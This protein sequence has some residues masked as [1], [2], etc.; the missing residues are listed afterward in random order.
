MMLLLILLRLLSVARLGICQG[1]G[2]PIYSTGLDD[3]F[4]PLAPESRD[5]HYVVISAPSGTEATPFAPYVVSTNGYPFDGDWLANDAASQ[6]VGPEPG[7]S[8]NCQAPAGVYD[9]RTS[10]DLTGVDP[11]SV[12]LTFSLL[13]DGFV[14]DVLV[15]GQSAG[16]V[17]PTPSSFVTWS[18][19]FEISN[20]LALGTNTLDFIVASLQ[21]TGCNPSGLR[22][23]IS[24]ALSGGGAPPEI[25]LP[26]LNVTTNQGADVVFSVSATGSQP[27]GYQW[28][29]DQTNVLADATSPT[30]TLSDVQT[31]QAGSYAVIVTNT[32]GSTTSSSAV[33][34]VE[35]PPY[36][37]LQPFDA[38]TNVGATVVLST[39][40]VGTPPPAYQWVY[41]Q[42]NVLTGA[43]G[44][45]L[46]L[47]DIQ[48]NQ[49][50]NYMVIVTNVAGSAT[51]SS[52]V[53]T[54]EVPP[55]ITLQ[56][57]TVTTNQGAIVGFSVTATGTPP[58]AY[59][60]FFNETTL[61]DGANGPTLVLGDVQPDDAGAYAVVV[62]NLAGSAASASAVLTVEVPPAI[63][64]QPV[65]L[66]TTQGATITFSVT[67][68]STTP[69]SYQWSFNGTGIPNATN[70]T[71]TL[72]NVQP[73]NAGSYSVLVTNVGGA[74]PSSDAALIV[75]VPPAGGPGSDAMVTLSA[76]GSEWKIF[77]YNDGS[78]RVDD[79]TNQITVS[80]QVHPYSPQPHGYL[81]SSTLADFSGTINVQFTGR[82]NEYG[83]SSTDNLQNQ[84]NY[85]EPNSA[86]DTGFFGPQFVGSYPGNV[87]SLSLTLPTAMTQNPQPYRL[88]YNGTNETL[89]VWISLP[90]PFNG[91]PPYPS[92]DEAWEIPCKATVT[93][94]GSTITGLVEDASTGQPLAG[95]TAVV[96]AQTFTSDANGSFV[97]PLLPPGPL[98][99]QITAPGYASWQKTEV[100][101][102]FEAVDITFNLTPNSGGPVLSSFASPNGAHFI[103]GMPGT[104]TF[105]VQ[106]AWN[107]SPGTATFDVAGFTYPALITD[108]GGGQASATLT[109]PAP[110]FVN[111]TSQLTV[112]AINGDGHSAS[113]QPQ[114]HFYPVPPIVVD[115]YGDDIPWQMKG[116]A[117]TYSTKLSRT[118]WHQE[119]PSGVYSSTATIGGELS[120]AYDANAGHFTGS[121][122]L[123]GSFDEEIAF[124]GMKNLSEGSLGLG[125]KL[126]VLMAGVDPPTVTPSWEFTV[127][128][129]AGVGGPAAD[130]VGVIFPV[131]EPVIQELLKV[132][133]LGP[134]LKAVQVDAYIVGELEVSGKYA[135][136]Q[137]A[138]CFL[139]TSSID[140]SGSLGFELE[141]PIKLKTLGIP[142]DLSIYGGGTGGPEIQVC[143]ELAFEEIKFQ[144]YGG[145]KYVSASGVTEWD[146]KISSPYL[147][148]TS[149]GSVGLEQAVGPTGKGTE[150][151]WR[152]G[153]EEMLRWGP[154]NRLVKP[155][156]RPG[157]AHPDDGSSGSNGA[158]VV[159]NVTPLS[160]PAVLSDSLGTTV[161]F[162]MTDP[163]QPWN[164]GT[165]IGTAAL[166]GS[167]DWALGSASQE[168][169]ADYCPR[170]IPVGTN[171]ALASW[172]RFV[173]AASG[174][175]NPVDVL[176]DMEIAAAWLDRTTGRWTPPVQL[177]TNSLVDRDPHPV[178][179]A[180]TAGIVWV[181]NLAGD[182][183]GDSVNGDQLLFAGW[184]GTGWDAPQTLWSAT[185]GILGVTFTADGD[186][187]A[188]VVF[189][190]DVD[191]NLDTTA[192]LEL[193]EVS[194]VG[195]IWQPALRL[196]SDQVEDSLPTLVAPNGVP[197][198]VWSAGG[199]LTYSTLVPWNPKPLFSQ[200]TL[201]AQAPTLE[202]ATVPGGA[203]IACTVQTG[204]GVEIASSYY[205]A[206][207]DQWSLPAQ[208]T[209]DGD[210][211]SA[212]S[213]G[214]DGQQVVV[215][216]LKT[217][218][219]WTNVDFQVSGQTVTV[220]NVPQ[221]GRTDLCLLTHSLGV[222]VAVQPGS[223]KFDPPNPAPGSVVTNSAL[224]ENLGDLPVQNLPLGFYDG[225]PTNGGVLI[226]GLQVVPGV[227]AG[228]ETQTVSVVW[229]L[230]AAPQAHQVY[231]VADPGLTLPDTDRSN[232]AASAT[233]VL[234]DIAIV[235][236]RSAFAS[237]SVVQLTATLTNSGVIPTGPFAVSWR[238][239]AVDGEEIG[240]VT[241]DSL[242]PGDEQDVSCH[243]T[244]SG[245]YF[246]SSFV[247]VFVVADPTN[248]VA[249]LDKTNNAAEQS[250]CV[251]P[252]W[253][254]RIVGSRLLQ[255][256]LLELD[257][258]TPI[259]SNSTFAVQST[260]SLDGPVVWTVESSATITTVAPGSYQAQVPVAQG[261]R[262][263]RIGAPP[264]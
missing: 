28:V 44:P 17:I 228:A 186:G 226:G 176:P 79:L 150:E 126:D 188:H 246:P 261:P 237:N 74:T 212:L 84:A 52:A 136:G 227:L 15:N 13:A 222:D 256:G 51:S 96:G 117:S 113:I 69:L 57:V 36:I 232:N 247:A 143:P 26:P 63:T 89:T 122:A 42:T 249:E 67:A 254:P 165:W 179:F 141:V 139:G 9:Y 172:V 184:N 211:A 48:T 199:T 181:Q 47:S 123:Q 20:Q 72:A 166:Q 25:T 60:W 105:S 248:A 41:E 207:L 262:F 204:S 75:N 118:V 152:P 252:G 14:Q 175:T 224:I 231:V 53:L 182:V 134:A 94:N 125:G 5:E 2:V 253:V 209:Q 164:T 121:A 32:A 130:V 195:G 168:P 146:N 66:I 201:S 159:E 124:A 169:A 223:V 244:T 142:G 23:Q 154:A 16:L 73:A 171:M 173:G 101:A 109:V 45:T 22:V 148:L 93:G 161:L 153:G 162:S 55:E 62:T 11:A 190:V 108:L 95:A 7:Y 221:P 97:T 107:G 149:D 200:A 102:P 46:T 243:W 120:A 147:T 197:I 185:S 4:R 80:L 264:Q 37:T 241:V 115:W 31:N 21:Q 215:A 213:L 112:S 137:P 144:V 260:G 178:A 156:T 98:N 56:P 81:F 245:H 183:P 138:R 202:A 258:Q 220:T 239:G 10:F 50:G 259:G 233:A 131:L 128:G 250:V 19:P 12:T 99:I 167:G 119:L 251:V 92:A 157:H 127:S 158:T 160:N 40:A 76:S 103:A 54:V 174:L 49:A 33:L 3:G 38:V 88:Y 242:A 71:L 8:E 193:Y 116:A 135:A 236:C 133:F 218:T 263:F 205:N 219:I 18:G 91:Y 180:N 151:H 170:I 191:G 132:P 192:D 100:L 86:V 155:G 85:T 194:T 68:A 203:V 217:Q 145:I 114:V 24:G 198:C 34:T 229:T 196:T 59:Q 1:T 187:E 111:S 234:P 83:L 257:F 104:L 82:E 189:A 87:A 177:T 35:F 163:S 216:Y 27:L 70:S 77:T 39:S 235:T 225:N 90:S 140:V 30:L 214:W 255:P 238:L 106:I 61:L 240:R 58:L 6:W 129:K 65:S 29:F 208:L 230:S 78:G 110:V 206:N 210:A 64:Q 43:N